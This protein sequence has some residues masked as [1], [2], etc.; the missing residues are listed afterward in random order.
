[1]S[2]PVE[3]LR[4]QFDVVEQNEHKETPEEWNERRTREGRKQGQREAAQ[5]EEKLFSELLERYEIAV[6][7][8]LEL[9]T[10]PITPRKSIM[11]E[12]MK[13]G[14]TGFVYGERG[15]G[16]TWFI[17]AIAVHASTGQELEG[18]SVTEPAEVLLIDGEMPVDVFRDRIAGMSRANKRLHTLHHEILFDRTGLVMNLTNERTQRIITKLCIKKKIKLLILDNLSCLFSALRENEAD[19][20]EKVLNW[21]LD[22]RR[23]RIAFLIV[24]HASRTGTMRGTSKRED[25]AFW[26]IRVDEVKGRPPNEKGARFQ[27]TFTKQRNSASPEWTREWTFQTQSEGQISIGCTELSFDSKVLQLIQD[28]LTRASDIADELGVVRSTVSKTA[29]RL[30]AAKLIEIKKRQYLPRGFMNK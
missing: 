30:E 7:T 9:E 26:V 8:S 28:G 29:K 20:W 5:E 17:D 14:D 6:C 1:M 3:R 24:H 25:S 16:K 11:G 15:S 13:E 12:W 22:L 23:R 21:L 19:E 18:W 27:T 2:S 4:E 10:I